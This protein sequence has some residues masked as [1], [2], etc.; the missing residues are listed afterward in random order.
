MKL[1]VISSSAEPRDIGKG[2]KGSLICEEHY[3][4]SYGHKN[5]SESAIVSEKLEALSNEKTS[6]CVLLQTEMENE[7]RMV[8][9]WAQHGA[10]NGQNPP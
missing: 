5:E 4:R 6:E 9:E 7:L 10:R 2:G 8:K 1:E 3:W